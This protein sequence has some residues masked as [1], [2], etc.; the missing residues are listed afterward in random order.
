MTADTTVRAAKRDCPGTF[1]AI[2]L[3]DNAWKMAHPE[4]FER[5]TLRFVVSGYQ[6]SSGIL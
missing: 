5:P 4:R 6:H 3:I 2:A 1:V